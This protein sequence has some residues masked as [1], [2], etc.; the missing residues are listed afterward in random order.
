MDISTTTE[1]HFITNDYC[2]DKEKKGF[3]ALCQILIGAGKAHLVP[4]W[5]YL[6]IIIWSTR[7]RNELGE[8]W[9]EVDMP[10]VVGGDEV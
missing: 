3:T 7:R 6:L 1:T 2:S 9:L 5:G 8:E 4:Y 10:K